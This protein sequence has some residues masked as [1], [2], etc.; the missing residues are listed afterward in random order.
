MPLS[1]ILEYYCFSIDISCRN[2]IVNE[3]KEKVF[4]IAYNST[5]RE[6]YYQE[7]LKDFL[8]QGVR[9]LRQRTFEPLLKN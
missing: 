5:T 3:W 6:P 8:I 1:Y 4:I 7:E 9:E 2:F